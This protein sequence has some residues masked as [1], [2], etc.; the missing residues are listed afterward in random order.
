MF[1]VGYHKFIKVMEPYGIFNLISIYT[2]LL[3]GEAT[4]GMTVTLFRLYYPLN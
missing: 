2:K 1:Q 4:T 3:E